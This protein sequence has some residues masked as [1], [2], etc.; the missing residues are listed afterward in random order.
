MSRLII[1]ILTLLFYLPLQAQLVPA[2][3]EVQNYFDTNLYI[4]DS[5]VMQNHAK[6]PDGY[7]LF[8]PDNISDKKT[9]VILFVHGYGGYNPMIYG[10]WIKHLVYQGN[11]V[12]YPRYQRNLVLPR[13][14]DF[15]K[16]TVTA[17]KDAKKEL[18]K[19]NIN[20]NW[21]NLSMIGHSYGGVIIADLTAHYDKYEIPKPKGIML[22]SPGTAWMKKGRYESYENI[23][24]DVK[25]VIV[26]SNND[27]T[28]GDEFGF[29]VFG[30]ARHTTD[31][32]MF[33]QMPDKYE[34]HPITAGHNESYSVDLN[35]DNGIRNYTAKRALNISK[36][37]AVDYNGYWRLFDTLKNCAQDGESCELLFEN[38]GWNLGKKDNGEPLGTFI[39]FNAPKMIYYSVN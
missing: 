7:W 11:I 38:K 28:V 31:K 30:T 23:P 16:N 4:S 10:K 14:D 24:E 35:F 17:I 6:R 29:L 39:E 26:V 34:K 19:Q 22:V 1:I 37:N 33:K 8:L 15:A 27:H 18:Q 3:Y 13:P 36:L 32:V 25:M 12:I 5:V 9:D 20:A 2:D 21:D